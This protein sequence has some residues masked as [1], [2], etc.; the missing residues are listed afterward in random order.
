MDELISNDKM[1]VCDTDKEGEN[2]VLIHSC[3]LCLQKK[4]KVAPFV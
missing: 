4:E 3:V 1:Y 2:K